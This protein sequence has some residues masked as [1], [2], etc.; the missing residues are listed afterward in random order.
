VDEVSDPP[1]TNALFRIIRVFRGPKIL[2]NRQVRWIV[3][4][5]FELF[6]TSAGGAD[7]SC[8]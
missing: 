7:F 1:A 2:E 4:L 3:H 6:G 8:G 5:F